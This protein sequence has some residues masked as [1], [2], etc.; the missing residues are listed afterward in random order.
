MP[1]LDPNI[2]SEKSRFSDSVLLVAMLIFW[3][4]VYVSG[5][6]PDAPWGDGLGYALAI[7][8]GWDWGMNAN[9]HFLYLN[10]YHLIY[11]VFR[12]ENGLM[13]LRSASVFWALA[14]LFS[15]YR[16]QEKRI[17]PKGA[18]LALQMLASGFAF[19]R[20]AEIPEVYTMALCTWVWVLWA[21]ETWEKE[22]ENLLHQHR[23]M[24]FLVLAFLVHVQILLL[25]PL[26]LFRAKHH[27]KV[28][29][30]SP[31]LWILLPL[32]LAYY[33][34]EILNLHSWQ[35]ILTENVGHKFVDGN[36]SFLWKGPFMVLLILV[37]LVP[38]FFLVLVK[39][40]FPHFLSFSL[41]ELFLILGP[42]LLFAIRFPEPGIYV[43]LLP[44][45]LVLS[46]LA[47]ETIANL[48]SFPIALP[49]IL[50][51]QLAWFEAQKLGLNR[52]A[53]A[54]FRA[55]QEMKGGLGF[56]CR[57]WAKG[58]VASV[59]QKTEG[60]SPDS[61]PSDLDWNVQQALEWKRKHPNG[62]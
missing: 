37:W 22:P 49:L 61:L 8:N 17:G 46:C 12:L 33:A 47:A 40:R 51:F 2:L 29:A 9:S 53:P 50:V 14:T 41:S 19:W 13:V 54:S 36:L 43:F 27:R 58:N 60:L 56:I 21:L 3:L 25:G 4:V 30:F 5:M 34:V 45:C 28:L 10:L 18:F 57:P 6:H 52:F 15:L 62:Q 24:A 26:L 39:S 23:L 42:I 31:F 35:A 20:H 1:H 32:G 59:L 55:S 44:A 16:W 7:E 48:F 11:S 38:I